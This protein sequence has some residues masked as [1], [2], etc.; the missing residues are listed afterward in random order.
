MKKISRKKF[1]AISAF[2]IFAGVAV[3]KR[4]SLQIKSVL[5]ARKI[6]SFPGKIKKDSDFSKPGNHLAG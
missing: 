5:W 3:W 2:A 4:L 6:S 1:I